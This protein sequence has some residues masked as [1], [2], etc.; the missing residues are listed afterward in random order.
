MG[1]T[2]M[3]RNSQL[4]CAWF[5]GWDLALTALAWLAAYYLRFESGWLPVTKERPDFD[6]CWRN[7]PLVIVLAAVS[8]RVAG[9]YHVHRLRRSREEMVSVLRGIALMTLLVIGGIFTV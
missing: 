7:L 5:V 1:E 6:L 2:M 3:N 9:Q 8:Y 4:L